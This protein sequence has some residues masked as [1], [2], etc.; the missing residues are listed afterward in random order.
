VLV[1]QAYRFELDPSSRVADGLSSHTGA[2]RFAFNWGLGLVKERLAL[3]DQ[4]RFACYKELLCDEETEA[5]VKTIVVPWTL[6]ALRKEWNRVKGEVAPWWS[7]NSKEAYNSGLD[8]LARALEGYFKAKSGERC[9]TV[10]VPPRK[11]KWAK[12][13]CRFTTGA[14]KVVD[15]HHVQLPRLGVIRTKESTDKLLSTVM[16]GSARI[17]SATISQE[18]GRWYVSFTTEVERND[19]PAPHPDSLV[20]VDLGIAHLATLSNGTVIENPRPFL[21]TSVG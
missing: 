4:V 21:G 19:A 17:L 13:S 15:N 20:A 1:H 6:A 3:R 8:A 14:I 2:S 16:A 11:K 18:A 12:K 5:L 10:G 7:E 9:G